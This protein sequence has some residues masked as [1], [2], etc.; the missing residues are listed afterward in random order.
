MKSIAALAL[1]LSSPAAIAQ[2]GGQTGASSAPAARQGGGLLGQMGGLLGNSGLPAIGSVGA[3][4]AAGLLGYC[5]KNR[6]LGATGSSTGAAGVLGRLTGKR[7][8]TSSPEYKA[9]Q[10]GEVQVPNGE[11]LSLDSLGGQMKNQV[12]KVVLNR[13]RSFL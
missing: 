12:C 2:S 7:A 5:V 11:A 1:L 6:L 13:A 10:A 4:N 9:G 3:G 8:I